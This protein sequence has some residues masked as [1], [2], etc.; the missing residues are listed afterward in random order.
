M[1]TTEAAPRQTPQATLGGS[2]RASLSRFAVPIIAI[3]LFAVYSATEP[4]IFFTWG[5]IKAMADS[6]AIVLLLA[7][8][9]SLPVR[10][11]DLDF[12]PAAVMTAAG[13]TLAAS[14][15]AGAPA[16]VAVLLALGVGLGVGLI[17]AAFI[18]GIGVDSLVMTLGTFIALGGYAYLITGSSVLVNIPSGI[19]AFANTHLFGLPL[20]TWYGWVLVVAFWYLY[21]KTPAGRY[22]LFVGG[23]RDASRLA[24]VRVGVVRS[25][26]L[27]SSALL[28]SFAGIVLVGQYAS[29][30]PTVGPSY[31]LQPAAAVFLGA[32]TIRLG[33]VNAW[34]TL[35]AL[36]LLVIGVTGLQL[37]GATQWLNSVFN[38]LALVIAITVARL[39]R[40]RAG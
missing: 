5:N 27:V 6:Q 40:R 16:G 12:S 32:T 23:S 17:H 28:S 2:V 14:Y 34:G 26:A 8:A 24:G 13:A 7:L 18:V 22:L 4:S 29:L 9:T 37:L 20:A 15:S 19:V 33:R 10:G 36:Y 21:E 38:G 1:T 39:A 25:S 35:F 31:L 11:G 3:V 30:D